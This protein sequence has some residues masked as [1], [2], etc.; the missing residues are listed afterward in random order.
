[1]GVISITL[2]YWPNWVGEAKGFFADEGIRNEITTTR[3]MTNGLSAL[4]GGSLHLLGGSPTAFIQA[5]EHGADLIAVASGQRDPAYS[6]IARPEIGAVEDL[7][8]RTVAVSALNG[9]DTVILRKLLLARG[10]RESDVDFTIAGGTPE[11][12]AAMASGGAVAALLSQPQDLQA[13]AQGY[14]R[15]A[16]STE[17]LQEYQYNSW[18]VRRDWAQNNEDTL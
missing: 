11:R 9:G 13:L 5:V 3:S 10:L 4:S 18:V 15:L 12:Y 14:R 17:V 16:L 6:L 8:G 7:R 2:G 1:M